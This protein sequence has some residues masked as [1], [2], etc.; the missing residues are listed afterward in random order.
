[1]KSTSYN[2]KRLTKEILDDCI[3]TI[4]KKVNQL[5]HYTIFT[6]FIGYISFEMEFLRNNYEIPN[7]YITSIKRGKYY[8]IIS[9]GSKNGLIK[10][11]YNARTNSFDMKKGSELLFTF[12]SFSNSVFDKIKK[13]L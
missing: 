3:T 13:Y 5:P 8:Y 7:T 2:Y 11:Y 12:N 4:S 9:I 6:G 10:A 1:M